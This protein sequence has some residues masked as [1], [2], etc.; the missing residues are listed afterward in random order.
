L[1][2][3]L[4][5]SPHQHCEFASKDTQQLTDYVSE[6]RNA[7]MSLALAMNNDSR[8]ICTKPG[9]SQRALYD[10]DD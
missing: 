4:D 7:K 5:G 10:V 1:S 2:F 9:E 8:A 3:A 6:K